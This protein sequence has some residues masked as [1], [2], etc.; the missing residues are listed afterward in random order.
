M[1]GLR[2]TLCC[3][4]CMSK[5]VAVIQSNYIP[6]KGYFDIINIADEFILYDDCQYTKNDWRNRNKIKTPGGLLWLTVPV[7]LKGR[8]GQRICEVE[9]DDQRWTK[10]HWN[11]IKMNYSRAGAYAEAAPFLEDLYRK[12]EAETQLSRVN[13]LFISAI[14]GALGIDTRITFSMDYTDPGDGKNEALLNL[15]LQ[16]RATEYISGPSA[17]GYI[18]EALFREQGIT[19]TWMDYSAYPEYAQMYPPFEHQVSIVDLLLH[20]GFA[21]AQRCLKSFN[22]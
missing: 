3:S 14:C 19:I 5:K 11:S 1:S 18:N 2:E 10:K 12:A 13:H 22:H 7:R 20:A 15:L 21:G 4:R 9:I 8:F 6:W 17:R 16:A